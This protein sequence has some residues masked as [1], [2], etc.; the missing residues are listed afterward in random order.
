MSADEAV[1]KA[2]KYEF[3]TVDEVLVHFREKFDSRRLQIFEL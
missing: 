1:D 2:V 3:S